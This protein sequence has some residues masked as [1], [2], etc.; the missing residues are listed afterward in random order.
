MTVNRTIRIVCLVL[1]LMCVSSGPAA[2][3]DPVY[4]TD[5]V[6]GVWKTE[7]NDK[8]DFSH[9]EVIAQDGKY[10]G[11]IVFLSSPVYLDD[12]PEG[13]PGQPR[14]DHMNP[15]TALQGRPLLG[16][17]LMTGFEHNGKNKWEDGRIY[18]PESG[19]DFSSKL[20]MK[21]KDTLEVFGYVKVGFVKLGRDTIWK[22][23]MEPGAAAE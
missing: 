8:G 20:T 12:E 11:R 5:A 21:D 10:L 3:A 14:A 17:D 9:V 13:T 1:G 22:R 4:D 18:D 23:V 15:D 16:I 19:K 7:P 6:L 2:A